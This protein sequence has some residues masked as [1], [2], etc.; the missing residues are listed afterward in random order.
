N[1]VQAAGKV[2][3]ASKLPT[4]VL[5]RSNRQSEFGKGLAMNAL[6]N[7]RT[8][9]YGLNEEPGKPSPNVR[10]AMI[11]RRAYETWQAKGRPAGTSLRDWLQAEKEVDSA[12]KMVG[13]CYLCRTPMPV[14]VVPKLG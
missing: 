4:L 5:K 7:P 11:Q 1:L 14:D 8:V 13:W 9:S 12:A 2:Q 6:M 3:A 10:H